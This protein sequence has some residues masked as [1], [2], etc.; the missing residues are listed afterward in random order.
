MTT[1]NKKSVSLPIADNATPA[2]RSAGAKKRKELWYENGLRFAC[3][4]CGN[5]CTGGPGYVW[6]TIDDMV[7]I[8]KQLKMEVDAFTRAYV[9]RVGTRYSLMEQVNYDCVFLRRDG[10]GKAGCAIYG[11][12]PTQCRTWPFW[13][14]NLRAPETWAGAAERCPGMCDAE[15]PL[16][17]VEH[18]EK[19]R[20][21]PESP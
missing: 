12:R 21:H 15:A 19:C 1:P 7:K 18:I 5:C 14:Q 20:E 13:N 17:G 16:Y 10:S 6:L 3:T 4:Q 9:K 11:V 2:P 8:A